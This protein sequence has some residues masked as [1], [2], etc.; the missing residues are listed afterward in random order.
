M[1]NMFAVL[2][3][4]LSTSVCQGAESWNGHFK[5]LMAIDNGL[6]HEKIIDISCIDEII[7][8]A[9][10]ST[11]VNGQEI[12]EEPVFSGSSRVPIKND[13]PFEI[14]KETTQRVK[15]VVQDLAKVTNF[16]SAASYFNQS[17][18]KEISTPDHIQECRMRVPDSLI[19]C[20]LNKPLVSDNLGN[21]TSW[22]L[23]LPDF[24]SNGLACPGYGCPVALTKNK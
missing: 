4:A 15:R 20:R 3:L 24:S 13:G 23:L 18:Y 7:C 14:D 5:W 1:R 11:Q 17:I 6:H 22:V 16:P 21:R 8:T 19:I 9:R 12:E 2:I 10:T